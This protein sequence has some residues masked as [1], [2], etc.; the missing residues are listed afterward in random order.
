MIPDVHVPFLPG[1]RA[2][3]DDRKSGIVAEQKLLAV[4]LAITAPNLNYAWG[5][6]ARYICEL[7]L[8]R[9]F[10]N[11]TGRFVGL[12][13]GSGVPVWAQI[14]R[15]R[16]LQNYYSQAVS[17]VGETVNHLQTNQQRLTQS[18][19]IPTI[20]QLDQDARR[21]LKDR[22][23]PRRS[24]P[25]TLLQAAVQQVLSDPPEATEQTVHDKLL[26]YLHSSS[27]IFDRVF[28]REDFVGRGRW[29]IIITKTAVTPFAQITEDL[30]GNE[31]NEQLLEE[32]T[33]VIGRKVLPLI[34]PYS[35]LSL[36]MAHPQTIRDS[37]DLNLSRSFTSTRF[38]T[39][40]ISLKDHIRGNV[41]A[42]PFADESV[43]FISSI[44][45]YPYYLPDIPF[46]DQQ[47]GL[48]HRSFAEN[49]CRILKPGGIA[50]LAPFSFRPA[51]RR[52]TKKMLYDLENY[53]R[54]RGMIVTD[55]AYPLDMLRKQMGDRELLLTYMS[56]IFRDR[57]RK[58]LRVLVIEKPVALAHP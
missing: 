14:M 10:Q 50:I 27:V 41:L 7:A 42:L 46:E 3:S 1:E 49:V 43:S 55:Q 17:I 37:T 6:T 51:G 15:E 12:D 21:K 28:E 34:R 53:W 22:V 20:D 24:L 18:Q 58:N 32:V 35:V 56:P 16:Q 44:E 48:D 36:D 9:A 45:G 8:N 38:F 23:S 47:T 26:N 4:V 57:R 33:R 30:V 29:E 54:S 39:R 2:Y 31:H 5:K 19:R 11:T 52:P 25:R 13:L 40:A